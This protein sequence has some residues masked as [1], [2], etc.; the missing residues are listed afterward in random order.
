MKIYGKKIFPYHYCH[1][2]LKHSLQYLLFFSSLS[3]FSSFSIFFFCLTFLQII[4]IILQFCQRLN[5]HEK[6]CVYLNQRLPVHLNW[7]KYLMIARNLS[8]LK[9]HFYNDLLYFISFK[10][11]LILGIFVINCP[12]IKWFV[13]KCP[14][15]KMSV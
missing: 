1:K 14:R 7:V 3:Y 11:S 9:K 4:C 10:C 12:V 15:D 13:L 2:C 6:V 5:I 8:I